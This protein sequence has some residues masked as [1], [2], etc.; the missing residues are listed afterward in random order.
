MADY[1]FDEVKRKEKEKIEK[2]IS[3]D[4]PK[5]VQI[6]K[7]KTKILELDITDDLF[8]RVAKEAHERDITFNAMVLSIIKDGLKNAEYRFEHDND[9]QFLTEE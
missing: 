9:P 5:S 2:K 6:G 3:G 1:N 8:L 7:E 4:W